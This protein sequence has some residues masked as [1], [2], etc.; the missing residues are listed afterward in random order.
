MTL[1][2]GKLA[3]REFLQLGEADA[4]RAFRGPDLLPEWGIKVGQLKTYWN[5]SPSKPR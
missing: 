5:G 4:S 2:H 3:G 1:P